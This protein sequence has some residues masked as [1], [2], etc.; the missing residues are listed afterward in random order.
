[1][2]SNLELLILEQYPDA[3]VTY[4]VPP[5]ISYRLAYGQ[6][7][8]FYIGDSWCC[9][10][11]HNSKTM[12]PYTIEVEAKETLYLPVNI[13]HPDI[14]FQYALQGCYGITEFDPAKPILEEGQHHQIYPACG[15]FISW[16]P[17]GRH[18]ILGYSIY[19][20][21]LE[22]HQTTTVPSL[23]HIPFTLLE[24]KLYQ[25]QK[26]P[27]TD[28]MYAL[29]Y[30]LQRLPKIEG[31]E[32]DTKIHQVIG[33]LQTA[34]TKQK[35][36]GP[37]ALNSKKEKLEGI[38]LYIK[39]LLDDGEQIPTIPEI[40]KEFHVASDYLSRIHREIYGYC[41]QDWIINKKLERAATLLLNNKSI[42]YITEWLHYRDDSNF[43]RAFKNKYGIS[44][45]QYLRENKP[46]S[47]ND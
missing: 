3:V 47:D 34:H 19:D 12:L 45:T 32:Q 5:G 43:S 11:W 20:S 25:S 37:K 16:V 41:L 36:S 29:L 7:I 9:M 2:R 42:S 40:A 31:I 21:W 10:Q 26:N 13:L 15:R 33:S 27:I 24:N 35:N 1:M 18:L 6:A 8:T 17:P 4:K 46:P 30:Q 14:H 38:H 28:E 22:K 39:K 44:P 23:E